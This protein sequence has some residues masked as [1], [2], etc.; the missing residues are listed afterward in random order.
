MPAEVVTCVL[1]VSDIYVAEEV[2]EDGEWITLTNSKNPDQI[3]QVPDHDKGG[4]L[5]TLKRKEAKEVHR[6]LSYHLNIAESNV[7]SIQMHFTKAN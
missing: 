3:I 7:E 1:R 2:P 5:R 6:T 4:V